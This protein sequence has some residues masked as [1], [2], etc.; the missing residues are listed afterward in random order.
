M[1]KF[2][3]MQKIIRSYFDSFNKVYFESSLPDVIITI[4]SKGRKTNTLG[5]FTVNKIWTNN[6]KELHEINLS[7]EYLNRPTEK[8][9]GT[10][11][12][13]M[14]H[15]Y[16]AV[17]DIKDVSRGSTYHNKNF[18][19]MAEKCGLIVT[20]DNRVGFG[21]TEASPE[22]IDFIKKHPQYY[23]FNIYRNTLSVR[24]KPK[25]KKVYYRYEC[26]VCSGKAR[27]TE[28]LDLVCCNELMNVEIRGGDNND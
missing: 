6:D 18:K 15:L 5:W 28:P 26:V 10:L 25:K 16:C 12:H 23:Q 9:L 19:E 3:E 20:K 4:Q 7:A 14:V 27:T 11:L 17:N 24:N 1:N 22:L 13:E 8:I 21:Y 2:I